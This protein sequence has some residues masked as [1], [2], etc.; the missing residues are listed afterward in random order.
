MVDRRVLLAIIVAVALAACAA[1]DT[2]GRAST[3]ATSMTPLSAE[4]WVGPAQVIRVRVDLVERVAGEHMII[5][6][7]KNIGER[8]L[9]PHILRAEVEDS[10]SRRFQQEPPATGDAPMVLDPEQEGAVTARFHLP[11]NAEPKL[12]I[13][14][15][16]HVDILTVP[17]P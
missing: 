6:K 13:V 7:V 14:S 4:L 12:L 5:Y 16:E 10:Q 11:Q 3:T 15:G 9:N 8:P 17:V 1:H 2:P